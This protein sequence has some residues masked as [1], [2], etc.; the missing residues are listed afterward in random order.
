MGLKDEIF[1]QPDVLERLFA[2]Q[3]DAAQR[4]ASR[5]RSA[6]IRYVFVA[7]RGTSDH[8]ALYA[9][10]LW[11]IHNRLVVAEAAPS[12]F[13]Q[14]ERPPRLDDALVV[15]I[16]Q[17]GQSPD[18]VGVLEEA[19]RQGAETVAITNDP[20]SPLARAA[21]NLLDICAGVENAV[22]ATKTY[23]AELGVV[24]MLSAALGE[25]EQRLAE[26]GT[27]PDRLRQAL[28]TDSQIERLAG[29]YRYAEHCVVLGRGYNYATAFEWALKLKELTHIA[30]QPYSSADFRH[31]PIAMVGRGMPVLAVA[32]RDAVFHDLL[33]LLQTLAQEQRA[34]LVVLSDSEEALALGRTPLRLPAGVPDWLTPLVAIGPAQLFCYHLTHVRGL[35]TENPR[36]L[37]KVTRTM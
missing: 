19:K 30:A 9:K 2:T 4:V 31:G 8:A 15:G 33:G 25:N 14:Y 34:D 16:S 37:R 11:G 17:S 5:A 20:D 23:T 7:A 22:A 6:T 32:P 29:R 21:D 27:V 26:L 1:E 13:T 24:A 36:G 3:M 18:I 12:L 10:Y 28:E 35:D